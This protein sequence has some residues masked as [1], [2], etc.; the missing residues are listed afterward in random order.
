MKLL[1]FPPATSPRSPGRDRIAFVA[2]YIFSST[3][4]GVMSNVV[5]GVSPSRRRWSKVTRPLPPPVIMQAIQ[6]SS[7][8]LK[9]I[10]D[11]ASVASISRMARSS[12]VS[13]RQPLLPAGST[14]S[15][16]S[17]WRKSACSSTT[18]TADGAT[19][20]PDPSTASGFTSTR[21]ASLSRKTP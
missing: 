9:R 19:S 11:E 10:A 7:N 17:G 3:R 1:M 18:T 20:R 14:S 21:N 15:A 8:S 12:A 2:R 6:P 4:P 5:A 16:H 13:G